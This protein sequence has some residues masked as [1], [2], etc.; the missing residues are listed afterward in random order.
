MD[1]EELSGS[2]T[3]PLPNVKSCQLHGHHRLVTI[4]GLGNTERLDIQHWDEAPN[5]TL[6]SFP[7]HLTEM[8]LGHL[9]VTTSMIPD[10]NPLF[11]PNLTTLTLETLTCQGSLQRYFLF[12]KLTHLHIKRAFFSFDY[13]EPDEEEEIRIASAQLLCDGPF[14]RGVPKL[15]YLSLRGM[16]INGEFVT[17]IQSC[18]L[19]W[20]VDLVDCSIEEFIPSF[21]SSLSGK[22]FRTLQ[23]MDLSYS[24]PKKSDTG[25]K[26]FIARCT[27]ER[28]QLRI[29]ASY[30]PDQYPSEESTDL[31]ST[32]DD[33]S[34]DDYF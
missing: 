22:K 25:Y 20:G 19:L 23:S 29:D 5:F 30:R 27:A 33:N 16:T 14:F 1:S 12:P 3:V 31:G 6:N 10:E 8:I 17:G 4:F 7:V 32:S 21:L 11:M 24:W 13:N 2:V 15:E 26:Q 28:P 18:L 34:Y 9:A